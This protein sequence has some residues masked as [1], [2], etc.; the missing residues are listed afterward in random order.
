M[1]VPAINATK[2]LHLL[3]PC[4]WKT[5]MTEEGGNWDINIQINERFSCKVLSKI[6]NYAK[7]KTAL[8]VQFHGRTVSA[9]LHQLVTLNSTFTFPYIF[10]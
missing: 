2:T 4:T 6:S 10:G 3:K 7:Q 5:Y 9:C 1:N 8:E